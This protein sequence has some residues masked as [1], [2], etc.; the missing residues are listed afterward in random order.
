MATKCTVC[1]KTVYDQE[2]QSYDNRHWHQACFKCLSC[3]R[4]I[5]V[6]SVAMIKGDLYCKACFLKVFKEKGSYASF[7]VKTLPN[8]KPGQGGDGIEA[9]T[10][11]T[12]VSP[13]PDE[14]K[15]DGSPTPPPVV[16]I[17]PPP[18][19][20]APPGVNLSSSDLINPK[21][22]VCLK[23]VYDQE[24]QVYDKTV[25]HTA[26]FKCLSCKRRIDVKAVAMISGD[27]YCKPC[28]MKTFKEKGS[29]ASF[30]PKTLPKWEPDKSSLGGVGPAPVPSSSSSSAAAA[31]GEPNSAPATSSEPSTSVTP[32][33][34]PVTPIETATSTVIEEVPE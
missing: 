23:T 18:A 21:C 14:G 3:K 9:S 8:W 20:Q 28:F 26:C 10:P 11:P 30:G 25:W 4:R 13:P 7:G 16:T 27:L 34:E 19:Q 29:Y 2:R 5:D 12:P 15:A 32:D 1:E 33:A 6:K 31:P 17:T 24:K 22:K